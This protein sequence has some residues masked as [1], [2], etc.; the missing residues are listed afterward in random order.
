MTNYSAWP[1][2]QL[3]AA[4]T[5][6]DTTPLHTLAGLLADGEQ[7][8]T[9]FHD[10]ARSS[11][12]SMVGG[13]SG[14]A[15][16]AAHGEVVDTASVASTTASDATRASSIVTDFAT[17]VETTAAQV[18][19][20]PASDP[21]K[22]GDYVLGGLLSPIGAAAKYLYDRHQ[23][24]QERQALATKVSEMDT[25]GTQAADKVRA[26]FSSARF[27]DPSVPPDTLPS[28]PVSPPPGG[29]NASAPTPTSSGG[30]TNGSAGS[31][32]PATGS[33]GWATAAPHGSGV[34]GPAPAV[35]GSGVGAHAVTPPAAHGGAA[36]PGVGVGPEN[37]S[38]VAGGPGHGVATPAGGAGTTF[39]AGATSPAGA[40]GSGYVPGAGGSL[41]ST[42]SVGLGASGGAG[43]PG[44]SLPGA[45]AGGA[46]VT[47]GA[48]AALGA[49]TVGLPRSVP[50]G[51]AAGAT[52]GGVAGSGQGGA[53]PRS[54][55]GS[56]VGR[57]GGGSASGGRIGGQPLSGGPR[58]IVEGAGRP[59]AAGGAGRG[60][61]P[62][63]RGPASLAEPG[64]TGSTTGRAGSQPFLGRPGGAAAGGNGQPL[65]RTVARG[66]S[67]T[68]YEGERLAQRGG[69]GMR[70]G[71]LGDAPGSRVTGGTD[72]ATSGSARSGLAGR[73][74]AQPMGRGARRSDDDSL[75]ERPDYLVESDEVWGDGRRV[76]RPVLGDR[77]DLD[78]GPD[79]P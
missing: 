48:S 45:V 23:A 51:W 78:G 21:P 3:K 20:M 46:A 79:V 66:S 30:S 62:L 64:G 24:E 57:V 68:T 32:V 29:S 31:A 63:G 13:W 5:T 28:P 73:A 15:A 77:P 37:A 8:A 56:P 14:D 41:P 60:P 17:D 54:S 2:D 67:G 59:G 9:T 65:R 55:P 16:V 75:R 22:A 76:A 11:M 33:Q 1:A 72:A 53:V 50:G 27:K 42:G 39:P 69:S 7:A 35:P 61:G 25:T 58:G 36:V 43:F 6:V 70:R 44:S 12:A 47:G 74:G 26:S 4:G 10:S 71:V 34:V 49:S 18:R 38:G 52:S 19:S 40:T